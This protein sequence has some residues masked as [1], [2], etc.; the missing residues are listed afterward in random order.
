MWTHADAGLLA[1]ARAGEAAELAERSPDTVA[2]R[3]AS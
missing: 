1:I 2:A 3:P